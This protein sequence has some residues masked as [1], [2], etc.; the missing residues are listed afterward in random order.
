MKILEDP[1]KESWGLAGVLRSYFDNSLYSYQNVSFAQTALT[2]HM[3]EVVVTILII[4]SLLFSSP[5][6]MHLSALITHIQPA[7]AVSTCSF[8]ETR[9]LMSNGRY[10]EKN[11]QGSWEVTQSRGKKFT[12]NPLS[13]FTILILKLFCSVAKT[14]YSQRANI[15][16]LLE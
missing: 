7:T 13:I 4:I 16:I 5:L 1:T 12:I 9:I 3:L 11:E 2:L 15:S 6:A 10:W 8:Y 14:K